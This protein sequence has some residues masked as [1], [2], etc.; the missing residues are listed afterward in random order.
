M[1]IRFTRNFSFPSNPEMVANVPCEACS[2]TAECQNSCR[3]NSHVKTFYGISDRGVWSLGSQFI[4]KERSSTPPNFEAKNIQFLKE[5][6]S[7]PVPTIVKDWREDDGRY[8]MLT[9]R[10]C[11]EPLNTV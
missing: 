4:L 1:E 8:F 11:G 3:Y 2:W 7:I 10:I 5:K 6:T 9:E